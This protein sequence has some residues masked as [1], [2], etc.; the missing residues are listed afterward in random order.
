M[1]ARRWRRSDRAEGF[2]AVTVV[3]DTGGDRGLFATYTRTGGTFAGPG[4]LLTSSTGGI[5]DPE[6]AV[7]RR[8]DDNFTVMALC[9][10][11][12]AVGG[13]VVV[14]ASHDNGDNW[15]GDPV[16]LSQGNSQPSTAVTPVLALDDNEL[17][18]CWAGQPTGGGTVTTWTSNNDY[19]LP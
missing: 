14:F 15:P 11:G 3:E 4:Q 18:A 8:P 9:N 1:L 5:R 16:N 19:S 2:V 7:Y 6:I 10:D 17:V 13:N 12:G